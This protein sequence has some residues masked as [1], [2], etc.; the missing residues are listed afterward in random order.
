MQGSLV[1]V[2]ACAGCQWGRAPAPVGSCHAPCPGSEG[3][4]GGA[5]RAA[6]DQ[7]RAVAAG[8]WEALLNHNLWVRRSSLSNILTSPF[9]FIEPVRKG[10]RKCF[11]TLADVLLYHLPYNFFSTTGA[12][13]QQ[14][15]KCLWNLFVKTL[16]EVTDIKKKAWKTGAAV[17]GLGFLLHH[18]C[19]WKITVAAVLM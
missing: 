15:W 13:V 7:A 19:T 2:A 17:Y 8:W 10:W 18:F 14:P 9:V 16:T 12:K 11:W 3:T 5:G 1:R 6:C 4:L